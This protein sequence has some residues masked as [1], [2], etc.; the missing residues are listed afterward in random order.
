MLQTTAAEVIPALLA[1]KD[2]VGTLRDR[3]QEAGRRAI[4]SLLA[5]SASWSA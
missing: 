5:G 2:E 1:L 4:R 3:F